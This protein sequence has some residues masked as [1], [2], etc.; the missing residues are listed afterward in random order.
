MYV[1]SEVL[2]AIRATMLLF[3]VLTI[4]LKMETIY[5]SETMVSTYESTRRQNPEERHIHREC[6]FKPRNWKRLIK[7]SNIWCKRKCFMANL[8]LIRIG[9]I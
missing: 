2:T 7:F 6:M 4:A 8:I 5:F 9:T 3:C 1:K